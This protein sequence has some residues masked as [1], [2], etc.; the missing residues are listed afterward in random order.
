MQYKIHK[1]GTIPIFIAVS[2]YI[3]AIYVSWVMISQQWLSLALSVLLTLIPAW[4][5]SFFRIPVFIVKQQPGELLSSADGKVVAVEQIENKSFPGQNAWQISVFMS[6]F[7]THLN[8][9]PIPGK[10][11]GVEYQKGRFLPAYHPK[12]SEL[13]E[14]NTIKMVSDNGSIIWIRQIAGIMA[15]R[16]VNYARIGDGVYAGQPLGFIKFGSRVDHFIP[17]NSKINV[18]VGQKVRAGKTVIAEIIA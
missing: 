8:R 7:N 5:I 6:P 9:Y 2:F 14:S 16:I 4:V 13:N 12:S 15:R 10:V 1:E 18:S 11:E 17:L 3:M